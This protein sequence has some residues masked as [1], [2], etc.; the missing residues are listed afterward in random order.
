MRVDRVYLEQNKIR[1]KV[2]RVRD[3]GKEYIFKGLLKGPE[4]IRAVRE[5]QTAR[6]ARINPPESPRRIETAIR[7]FE[8]FNWERARKM[9]RKEIDTKVPFIRIGKVP[10][11]TYESRKEG[12]T[13]QYAHKT[14]RMPTLYAH[15]TKP[16]FLMLGGSVKVKD[17]L[18]D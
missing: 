7:K 4:A 16:I 8:E 13:H 15:P 1:Q 14:K 9:V 2:T 3:S 11:I 10:V 5:F 17:W 6:P 18:I 12:R